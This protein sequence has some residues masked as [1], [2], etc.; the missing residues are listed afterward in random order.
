MR[1]LNLQCLLLAFLSLTFL[2]NNFAGVSYEEN[3][4][5]QDYSVG[6]LLSWA[7]DAETN[8]KYFIVERSIDGKTFTNIGKVSPKSED[9]RII[10]YTFE[11]LKLGLETAHYRLKQVDNDG[12]YNLSDVVSGKKFIVSTFTVNNAEELDKNVFAVTVESMKAASLKIYLNNSQGDIVQK[13]EMPL[14]EGFTTIPVDLSVETPG[15]Y[16]TVLKLGSEM[17]T[18]NLVRSEENKKE[19]ASKRKKGRG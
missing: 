1:K 12:T 13:M 10:K 4:S 16:T 2:P 11:D 18:L 14:T 19:V 7:T 5:V 3:L 17:E 9:G 8:N 15:K 6:F